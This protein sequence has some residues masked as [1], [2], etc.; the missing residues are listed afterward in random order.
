[1]FIRSER[2]FLR[3]AWPED[4][5]EVYEQVN[6]E[7]LVKNLARA[8]WPYTPGDARQFVRQPQGRR[9]PNFVVTL[10]SVS[11]SK[12]IGSAGLTRNGNE[13]EL[14]YWIGRN[15]R[16][17]GYATEAA[18]AVLQMAKALGHREL[19]AAHFLDNPASGKVLSRLGFRKVAE[20][21]MRFS[22]GRGVCAP[23]RVYR[24][25]LDDPKGCGGDGDGEPDRIAA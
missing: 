21:V 15:Y 18:G 2:L 13:A 9:Y 1:M 4:W 10:P 14:G 7:R 22:R 23:E 5:R 11:G 16:G 8:P 12:I 3:P 6:E 20:N 25:V 19:V 24:I 17:H